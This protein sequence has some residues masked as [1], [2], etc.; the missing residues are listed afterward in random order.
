MGVGRVKAAQEQ[1]RRSVRRT[2]DLPLSAHHEFE[3]WR[4]E[5]AADL[6]LT[7]V[8]GQEVLAALVDELLRD[9]RLSARIRKMI[10]ENKAVG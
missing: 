2:V 3:Q 7:R 5:T 8:T 9:K 10:V 6:G 4:H 1:A